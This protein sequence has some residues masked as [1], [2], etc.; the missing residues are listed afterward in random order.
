MKD[1]EKKVRSYF[2]G[3]DKLNCAQAI[4]KAFQPVSGMDDEEIASY[5]KAGGGKAPEGYCGA[6][7][8][9]QRLIQDDALESELKAEFNL[10]AAGTTCKVI[11]EQKKLSCADCVV[12]AAVFV[13]HH[14]SF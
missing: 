2:R 11:R 9:A 5:A 4:L 13:N 6:L 7:Y 8:A 14:V 12:R 3:K 10:S 1:I